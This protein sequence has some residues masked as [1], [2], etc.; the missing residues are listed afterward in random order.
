MFDLTGVGID[1][2]DSN[3]FREIPYDKKPTFY[4]KIFTKS[5]ID[6]CL[7][8]KD[9]Y[10][11]FAGI[12]AVKEAIRKS[13]QFDIDFSKIHTYHENN[14]PSAKILNKNIKFLISLSH[15]NNFSIAIALSVPM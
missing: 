11:H 1:L 10:K 8:F 12:F 7:K 9:P 3:R 5:E 13:I 14:V 4:K 6:Y 2:V 15:E